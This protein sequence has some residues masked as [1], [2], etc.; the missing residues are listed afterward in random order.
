V[1]QRS[2]TVRL[3]S[4]L[5]GRLPIDTYPLVYG[6]VEDDKLVAAHKSVIKAETDVMSLVVGSPSWLQNFVIG[7]VT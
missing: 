1:Q 4:A 5:H 6:G 3:L 7:E 2:N